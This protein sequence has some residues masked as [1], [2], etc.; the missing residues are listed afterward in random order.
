MAAGWPAK[1][2]YATGDV[3]SASNMNDIGGTLNLINPYTA[4][5]NAI[6]NGAFNV[7]QRQFTSNTV[8]G[9]YNFDRWC[10]VHGGTTGTVT[11]TPQTFT[12]GAA[13]VAGYEYTNYVQYVTAAGASADTYALFQ[14]ILED[15][16]TLAGQ[17]ATLSF[18]AKTASGTPKIGIEI[19]QNFGTGG[20]PSATVLTSISAVTISTSWTRYTVSFTVPSISGK[21]V[22]TTANTSQLLIYFWMSA[23]TSFASRASSIGL[24]NATFQMWGVQLEAGS[25]ATAFQT[26]SGTIGGELALCQRYYYQIA[27]GTAIYLGQI[28]YSSVTQMQ[29]YFPHKVSMRA[30]PTLTQVTGTNY[31]QT[32]DGDGINSLTIYYGNTEQSGW[33]NSTEAAG[34]KGTNYSIYT[35]NAASSLA[36]NAEF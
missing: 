30:T 22:G 20:S 3:L 25:T 32:A 36:L 4:G 8:A 1:V 6:I 16:R 31:Y 26:A 14:T 2:N 12:A 24:Q 34:V 18:W 27:T 23:G 7:N 15:V 21:T 28:S 19:G 5:K 17:T 33:Y 29:G 13:P 10:Q 35:N 9:T 11:C